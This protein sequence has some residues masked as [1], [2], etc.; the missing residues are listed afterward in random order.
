MRL[1]HKSDSWLG[2]IKDRNEDVDRAALG[3]L[4]SVPVGTEEHCK[5][6]SQSQIIVAQIFWENI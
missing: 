3:S 1:N 5:S 4:A 2:D 6:V